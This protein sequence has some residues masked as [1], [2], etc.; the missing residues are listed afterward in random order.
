MTIGQ[1][2]L[3]Y[4]IEELLGEG[5]MGV[6]FRAND[7]S[8]ERPVALKILH[9]HLLSDQAFLERFRHEAQ[10][11][12]RLNHPQITNLYSF[13][14]YDGYWIMVMEFVDGQTL[15]Q[16]L[17]RNGPVPLNKAV[18]WLTQALHGLHH[19][20]E[21]GVLHR[22]MKPANLM[23]TTSGRVKLMD[24]GIAKRFDSQRLTRV[25]HLIG[26]LEYMAPELLL[27]QPPSVASDLYAVGV[28]LYE[29]LTGKMPFEATSEPALI[30]AIAKQ[31]RIPIS[32]YQPNLPGEVT[33]LLSQLLHKNPA[34]RPL[35]A[36]LLQAA[37]MA[38]PA[39]KTPKPTPMPATRLV[40]ATAVPSWL[41]RIKSVGSTRRPSWPVGDWL[42][43]I[44]AN[45][46]TTEGLI[47]LASL[48]FASA[49]LSITF[50]PASVEK[51]GP[52]KPTFTGEI[53]ADGRPTSGSV[54]Q[55]ASLL[56][57]PNEQ[58]ADEPKK[59]EKSPVS[60]EIRPITP[61][62]G[63]PAPAEKMPPTAT[64]PPAKAPVTETRKP[65]EKAPDSGTR[66]RPTTGTNPP[67]S[68][69]EPHTKEPAP[70]PEPPRTPARTAE[71]RTVTIRGEDVLLELLETVS[72]EQAK[73]GDAVRLRVVRA[74]VVDGI[75]VVE[76][77]ATAMA[78]VTDRSWSA[79]GRTFL[80]I[81]LRQVATAGG[82]WIPIKFPP[83]S[84]SGS[85]TNPVDFP[86]GTRIEARLR[87]MT[88]TLSP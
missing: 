52:V 85:S 2:I 73:V 86:R 16:Y 84:R 38:L 46:R 82:G 74:V 15:D 3:S 51:K 37:L 32:R 47:L 11:L 35:T 9:R 54:G 28:L 64:K 71:A 49:I 14:Q 30:D 23:L 60:P 63:G 36:Q 1:T 21:C 10:T 42:R 41:G 4:R 8:L 48:A 80:E 66:K 20:H 33:S 79:R 18:D 26:T 22:D 70:E 55:Q 81:T 77:G 57:K 72:P 19:A 68:E 27:G 67:K 31:K 69:A 25:N 17:R 43:V 83:I 5:G 53:L 7:I 75:T 13:Q 39:P 78:S 61:V 56:P 76:A 40:S 65:A 12:A 88:L 50:W 24:F 62:A 87:S 44:G 58:P 45:I 6:V 59:V 34:Q 29:L